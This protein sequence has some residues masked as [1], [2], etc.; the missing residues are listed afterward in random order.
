MRYQS[1][2]LLL[3]SCS[4]L[5]ACGG[6]A[7]GLGALPSIPSGGASA[8]STSATVFTSGRISDVSGID[9][10]NTL[11]AAGQ[12]TIVVDGATQF[13][14]RAFSDQDVASDGSRFYRYDIADD[15]RSLA[16]IGYTLNGDLVGE[17]IAAASPA[18]AGSA[19]YAGT[20]RGQ[21]F[22]PFNG[23]ADIVTGNVEID[24]DFANGRFDGRIF[25][26][27]FV[28]SS[29]YD[30]GQLGADVVFSGNASSGTMTGVHADSNSSGTVNAVAYGSGVVG[31]VAVNH[32][33]ASTFTGQDIPEFGVFSGRQK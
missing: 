7:G 16:L 14:L 11:G 15:G 20:Y 1:L 31:T 28:P 6:G 2:S 32:P 26:R 21:F 4:V 12:A 3:L 27:S 8:A 5:F 29:G 25:N 23:V 17:Y 33:G 19:S 10:L 13:L 30:V 9:T 24:S 18:P 22:G